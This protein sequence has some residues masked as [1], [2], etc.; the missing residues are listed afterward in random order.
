MNFG[1]RLRQLRTQRN[2]TQPQ[3]AQA[4]G[5]EQ[6]YLSKLEN[7]KSVPGA[8]IFQAILR[9][10]KLDVAAFLEGVDDV[11][12]H[13]ELRQ[14]PEVA[15][16]LNGRGALRVHH[17]KRWLFGSALAGVVGL[18]MF[19]AGQQELLFPG[20]LYSYE[21]EGV[22]R[23]GEPSDLFDSPD[24]WLRN[25]MHAGVFAEQDWY[26]RRV[27]MMARAQRDVTTLDQSR[28]LGYSEAVP[29]GTR[30]Y[31]LM[32]Q[33]SEPRQQNRYLM[34]AGIV[35]TLC[36]LFG[37]LVEMRLRSVRNG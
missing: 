22:V 29:G 3:L 5:I 12:V 37:F 15:N 20:Q 33:T 23:A 27:E 1:D 6:S 16:H 18:S 30:F 7:D 26:K 31:Q 19:F 2:L 8:D 17:V 34:L 35:L 9:A 11:V 13:R 4:I 36:S 28:G 10:L 14:V 21:S 25:Q 32:S 24:A